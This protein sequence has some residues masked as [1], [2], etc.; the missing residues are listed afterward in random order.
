MKK[1]RKGRD[2]SRPFS[3]PFSAA[4]SS[5]EAV[6]GSVCDGQFVFQGIDH[7]NIIM[8]RF[9]LL[10]VPHQIPIGL[11][12]FAKQ[13]KLLP[14]LL[15]GQD[16]RT[17]VPFLRPEHLVA[18]QIGLIGGNIADHAF[19]SLRRALPLAC[20]KPP[21]LIHALSFSSLH[22]RTTP[23]ISPRMISSNPSAI[24]W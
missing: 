21:P 2:G 13:L 3:A 23:D 4:Q 8:G 17:A 1:H 6:V 22:R 11:I 18:F 9:V 10:P 7:V 12:T 14:E 5:S 24:S 19:I 20:R 16:R 15:L